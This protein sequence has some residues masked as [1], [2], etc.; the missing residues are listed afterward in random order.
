MYSVQYILFPPRFIS[1]NNLEGI[2]C[3][4]VV[5]IEKPEVSTNQVRRILLIEVMRR[6]VVRLHLLSEP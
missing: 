6:A 1:E 2:E 5:I 3:T 4:K